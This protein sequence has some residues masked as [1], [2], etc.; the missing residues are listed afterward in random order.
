M[1]L[2]L[3]FQLIAS[4]AASASSGA[5][6][7]LWLLSIGGL[8]WRTFDKKLLIVSQ[9]VIWGLIIIGSIVSYFLAIQQLNL[10][11]G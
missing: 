5:S 2:L 8:D 7:I 4:A 6:L 10:K 9:A 1:D 3:I 11:R